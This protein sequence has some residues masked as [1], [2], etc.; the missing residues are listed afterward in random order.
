MPQLE[1]QAMHKPSLVASI[2]ALLLLGC[3]L[4]TL[5]AQEHHPDYDDVDPWVGFERPSCLER[6]P[7]YRD[8]S[9]LWPPAILSYVS[10]LEGRSGTDRARVT[11]TGIFAY[12]PVKP[13]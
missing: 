1:S 7:A 9:W 13:P 5:P 6:R 3:V 8:S 4:A 2:T 12:W 10:W 11:M